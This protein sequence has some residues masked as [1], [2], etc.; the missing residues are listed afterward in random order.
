M[1]KAF[2]SSIGQW[3]ESTP[4]WISNQRGKIKSATASNQTDN[5]ICLDPFVKLFNIINEKFQVECKP[6]HALLC[7]FTHQ[8]ASQ[9]YGVNKM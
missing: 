1:N 5:L 4:N 2:N 3:I 9:K 7:T 8:K 6:F